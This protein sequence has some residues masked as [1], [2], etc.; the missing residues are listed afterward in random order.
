M[1]QEIKKETRASTPSRYSD[2]FTA[3]RAEMDRVFDNF[4]GRG[5]RRLPFLFGEET[6][7][8]VV[9]GVDIRE[10]ASELVLEAELPGTDEKDISISLNNGILTIKGEK[11]SEREEKDE[12]FHLMERSY[13]SFERSFQVPDTVDAEKVA[14]A[15][16]KGVLKIT[17]PKR[18]EALKAEKKIPIGKG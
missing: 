2:P 14:A 16:D 6:Q 12:N 5:F 8:L 17:M 1:A 4:L 15:F 13:G 18:A 11:K 10:N 3:M 9:P 7:G